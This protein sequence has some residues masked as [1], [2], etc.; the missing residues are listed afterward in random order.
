MKAPKIYCRAKKAT[1]NL[2]DYKNRKALL[3]YI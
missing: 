3:R 1:W 2:S